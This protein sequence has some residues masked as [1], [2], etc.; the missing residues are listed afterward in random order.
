MSTITYNVAMRACQKGR[1][2]VEALALLGRMAKHNIVVSTITYN[3]ANS[4][5]E[6]ALG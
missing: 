1:E 6:K 2:R 3:V 5:C 4:R